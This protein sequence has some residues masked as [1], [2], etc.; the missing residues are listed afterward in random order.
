MSPET[1]VTAVKPISNQLLVFF[2]TKAQFI[3][4]QL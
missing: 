4:A 1:Y 2:L 3:E